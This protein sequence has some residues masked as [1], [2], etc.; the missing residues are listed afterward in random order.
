MDEP[1]HKLLDYPR[2]RCGNRGTDKTLEEN[3]IDNVVSEGDGLMFSIACTAGQV[4]RMTTKNLNSYSLTNS[5][6]MPCRILTSELSN[7][8]Q[9]DFRATNYGMARQKSLL[10]RVQSAW[11]A[12]FPYRQPLTLD[13][14]IQ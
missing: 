3:S 13:K 1:Y 12:I 10:I 8:Q 7:V 6:R 14:T 2:G 5:H 4:A 9:Q 11:E